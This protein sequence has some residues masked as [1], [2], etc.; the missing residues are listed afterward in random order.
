MVCFHVFVFVRKSSSKGNY[1]FSGGGTSH[2]ALLGTCEMKLGGEGRI[3]M[4]ESY[5]ADTIRSCK[6]KIE[7]VRRNNRWIWF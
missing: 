4:E 1:S 7:H 2:L 6:N 5:A 3:L